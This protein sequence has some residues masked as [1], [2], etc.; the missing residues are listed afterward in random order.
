MSG[1]IKY[2]FGPTM[3]FFRNVCC[4]FKV[5]W[6]SPVLCALFRLAS[7]VFRPAP[8]SPVSLGACLESGARVT[9]C[10][11]CPEHFDC[12]NETQHHPSIFFNRNLIKHLKC[13]F[14]FFLIF[15]IFK[16]HS[17]SRYIFIQMIDWHFFRKWLSSSVRLF[18]T[19]APPPPMARLTSTPGVR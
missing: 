3:Y 9:V 8:A 13:M 5:T 7:L 4:I 1:K 2:F 15:R 14:N 18:L 11:S 17:V 6:Y 12:G 19:L 16:C 10:A